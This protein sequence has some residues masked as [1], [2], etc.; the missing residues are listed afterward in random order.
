MV[1]KRKDSDKKRSIA[2]KES[3]DKSVKDLCGFT[4]L[5]CRCCGRH[6]EE[7]GGFL[8]QCA[9]C[10]K[11]H[12]CSKECFNND[13]EKHMEFCQTNQP[14][15][16]APEPQIDQMKPSELQPTT[17]S[18]ETRQIVRD[19]GPLPKR[20]SGCETN[21]V[22]SKQEI[23]QSTVS[24]VD[25][26]K[27][28]DRDQRLDSPLEVTVRTKCVINDEACLEAESVMESLTENANNLK[29]SNSDDID[30]SGSASQ[31][32]SIYK[33]RKKP[34]SS[35]N[36]K[37]DNKKI[38][39]RRC[40]KDTRHQIGDGD[41]SACMIDTTTSVDSNVSTGENLGEVKCRDRKLR[42]IGENEDSSPPTLKNGN[43]EDNRICFADSDTTETILSYRDQTQLSLDVAAKKLNRWKGNVDKPESS[44]DT[45]VEMVGLNSSEK[46]F[47]NVLRRKQGMNVRR[48]R[49]RNREKVCTDRSPDSL[50]SEKRN[51][52]TFDE[53]S[54]MEDSDDEEIRRRR[55]GGS[56]ELK[57]QI[58]RRK[59]EF[60]KTKIALRA[61]ELPGSKNLGWERPTWT[62]YQYVKCRN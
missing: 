3:A 18:E 55:G 35:D 1:K 25:G 52:A 19:F 14:L 23:V 43:D 57:S 13:L 53:W 40:R 48:H 47:P 56:V 60:T 38:L 28:D 31:A 59:Q 58:A 27:K 61:P 5:S 51:S 10:R 29:E 36:R 39:G 34:K 2:L 17:T 54:D 44:S 22:T 4:E 7:I 15:Q 41:S 16:R 24:S 21:N 20:D 9:T 8:L 50:K 26:V 6:N 45:A 46:R 62:A 33:K 42:L 37:Q 30:R 11:A 12:Y 32:R 49:V